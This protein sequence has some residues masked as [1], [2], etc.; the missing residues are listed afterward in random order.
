LVARLCLAHQQPSDGLQRS[1]DFVFVGDGFTAHAI[2]PD[3]YYTGWANQ[4]HAAISSR[5]DDPR[6]GSLYTNGKTHFGIK[7]DVGWGTGGPLFFIHYS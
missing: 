6:P 4:R 3:L 2:S 1:D 7:L 5:I